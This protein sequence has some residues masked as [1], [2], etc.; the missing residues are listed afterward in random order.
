MIT[1]PWLLGFSCKKSGDVQG[2]IGNLQI[3]PVLYI[4]DISYKLRK[5]VLTGDHHL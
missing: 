1:I 4:M 5:E 2:K 3:A